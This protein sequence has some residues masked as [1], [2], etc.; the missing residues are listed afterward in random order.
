[1]SFPSD[2]SGFAADDVAS[3]CE[4][5]LYSTVFDV[6]DYGAAGDG[7]TDDTDAIEAAISAAITGGGNAFV[8]FPT[9]TYAVCRQVDNH[10]DHLYQPIFELTSGGRDPSNLCFI[11]DHDVDGTPLSIIKGFM[12]SLADPGTAF[13]TSTLGSPNPQMSRFVLFYASRG[14][15]SPFYSKIQFRSLVLDGQVGYTGDFTVGGSRKFTA[16]TSIAAAGSGYQV[17]DVLT[18]NSLDAPAVTNFEGEVAQITVNT[19]NG[20]GGV[21]SVTLTTA[22]R[23]GYITS[24]G[25]FRVTGGHGTGFQFVATTALTGDGW[26]QLHKAIY[27]FRS[28]NVLIYNCDLKNWKGEIVYGGSNGDHQIINCLV[29]GS[30]SS[31]ISTS[32]N[33]LISDCTLGGSTTDKVLNGTECFAIDNGQGLTVQRCTC[34]ADASVGN[35]LVYIGR[36]ANSFTVTGCTFNARILISDIASNVV[37]SDNTFNACSI[38]T[39]NLGLY[40]E[41]DADGFNDF[42][43]T[44]NTLNGSSDGNSHQLIALQNGVANGLVVS[45]NIVNGGTGPTYLMSG[46]IFQPGAV[47]VN[48]RLL[49]GAIDLSS[50]FIGTSDHIALWSE[51][52]Y[53]DFA[54][55]GYS[56][57]SNGNGD[58]ITAVP[59]S[60]NTYLTSG[61]ANAHYIQIDDTKL[62]EYP[63]GFTTTF[64]TSANYTLKKN[65]AWNDFAADV[66]VYPGLKIRF[67][68]TLFSVVSGGAGVGLDTGVIYCI[69]FASDADDKSGNGY[70]LTATGVTFDGTWATFDGSHWARLLSSGPTI[71]FPITAAI[72]CNFA[73]VPSGYANLHGVGN[74]WIEGFGIVNRIQDSATKIGAF[75]NS[76]SSHQAH[77]VTTDLTTGANHCLLFTY[78]GAN[79]TWYVDGVQK[80]QQPYA[81]AIDYSSHNLMFGQD[82]AGNGFYT[83]KLACGILWNRV[84]SGAEITQFSAGVAG[85]PPKFSDLVAPT[86]GTLLATSHTST[87]ASLSYATVTGGTPPYSNELKRSTV[88]GSGYTHVSTGSGATALYV[89]DEPL[90]P[91]TDYYYVVVTTDANS[92]TATSNEVHVKTDAVGTIHQTADRIAIAIGL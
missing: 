4:F 92:Q 44:G 72:W 18:P 64:R 83:G 22:G 71:A 80:D 54:Q 12:P 62:S 29:R 78:D 84:L 65:A 61:N 2:D 41:F 79:I 77:S 52:R 9:G 82:A 70:N 7:V 86:A 32:A 55:L 69:D 73:S 14:P 60:D 33:L 13:Q 34:S 66:A 37:I 19:I 38:T 40:P 88:S 28:D 51:T 24:G 36:L 48:N 43:I 10:A 1:M 8:Y 45:D 89:D 42:T 26:D 49:S 39:N 81:V 56:I 5:P 91:S 59:V 3:Y 57:N 20:S 31:A 87:S 46:G 6:T 53:R 68:G 67:N 90:T 76:Y 11:G 16:I 50:D 21:T 30:N 47:I 74:D 58:T 63:S 17:N 85:A 75:I 15:S 27:L 25:T 23:H 35:G